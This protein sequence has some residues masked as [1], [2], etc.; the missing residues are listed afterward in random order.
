[1]QGGASGAGEG[2]ASGAG[3]GK[4]TRRASMRVNAAAGG[5]ATVDLTTLVQEW[6]SNPAG[7]QGML[8]R[9]NLATNTSILQYRFASRDNTTATSRPKLT[10]TY[11]T[12]AQ[13]A[14][15]AGRGAGLASPAKQSAPEAT[16]P[17]NH[18]WR[19]YYHAAG[20]H[21]V[22]RVQDGTTS[23]NQVHYLFADHLGSTNVSVGGGQTVTQR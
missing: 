23:A 1:M 4:S 7:N 22:M 16:P 6:V 3:D 15:P 18:T 13:A 19:S 14:N 21:V 20:R 9:P 17:A 11:T 2:G 10:V 8:L 5:T 12:P